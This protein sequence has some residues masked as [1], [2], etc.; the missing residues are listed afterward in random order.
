MDDEQRGPGRPSLFR[1]EYVELARKL[2]RLGATEAEI[3]K[4]M[5][6]QP[7]EDEWLA[8]CL[9][10]IREDRRGV[11]AALKKRKAGFKRRRREESPSLRIVD[12]VRARMWAALKGRTDGAL[13]S[14]LGYAAEQLAEHLERQ[15]VP[16][17]SWENYGK[18]HIDHVRP[19]AAFDQ[20]DPAQFA[21]CWSLDNLQPLW[22]AE[23]IRKGAKYVAP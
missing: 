5:A 23:N 1:P 22:A 14:R 9:A 18:W 7:T 3:E 8:C 11:V 2:A 16:G 21:A 19:C 12:S 6:S 20:A 17:M 4:F 13:F 15:F 10:R